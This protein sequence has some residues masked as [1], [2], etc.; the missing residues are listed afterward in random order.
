M[1]EL[2]KLKET[3]KKIECANMFDKAAMAEEALN[4]TLQVFASLEKR[5]NILESRMM[6]MQVRD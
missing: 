3:I 5:I 1:I 4:S 6:A 2:M